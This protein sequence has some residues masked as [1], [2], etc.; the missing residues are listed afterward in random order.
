MPWK[1]C[2]VMDERLQ[3]VARRLAG[4]CPFALGRSLEPIEI[5]HLIRPQR[6]RT[7]AGDTLPFSW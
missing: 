6:A 1:K 7:A 5:V 2:S 4:D 3:F